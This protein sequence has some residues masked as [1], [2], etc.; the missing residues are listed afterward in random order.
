MHEM[1]ALNDTRSEVAR[2]PACVATV[3]HEVIV[4]GALSPLSLFACSLEFRR[5]LKIIAKKLREVVNRVKFGHQHTRR[6]SGGEVK[7]HVVMIERGRRSVLYRFIA[8]N[9]VSL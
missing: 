8:G 5:T 4:E 2:A 6:R 1:D 3:C 7:S 9:F